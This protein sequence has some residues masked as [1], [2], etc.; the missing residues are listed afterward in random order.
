[1]RSWLQGERS[2]TMLHLHSI[3]CCLPDKYS[4]QSPAY[5]YT[6]EWKLQEA[7]PEGRKAFLKGY[8]AKGRGTVRKGGDYL[9]PQNKFACTMLFES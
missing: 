5:S 6:N 9:K 8:K 1:M 2:V 3:W 4:C 7:S